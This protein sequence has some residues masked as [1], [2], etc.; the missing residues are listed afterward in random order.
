ME[1]QQQQQEQQ[2]QQ[3]PAVSAPSDDVRMMPPP[4]KKAKSDQ[5]GRSDSLP[6]T[7]FSTD[8][9]PFTAPAA[10][11]V[12]EVSAHLPAS[13]FDADPTA[14][15]ESESRAATTTA[16]A[17]A[18]TAAVAASGGGTGTA[19]GAGAA[20]LED[21]EA[22]AGRDG[23]GGGVPAGA[24]AE[25]IPEGFFD[26]HVQDAKVR[27]VEVKDDAEAEWE[28]FEK[29]KGWTGAGR[30]CTLFHV[31]LL[32]PPPQP[33]SDVLIGTPPPTQ[34]CGERVLTWIKKKKKLKMGCTLKHSTPY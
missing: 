30:V 3:P 14:S 25:T 17:V 15:N 31:A 33:P 9:A 16:A 34:H 12:A 6:S 23:G 4:V 18:A 29:G 1:K 24:A 26:D 5:S 32:P 2:Q 20:V 21:E 7:F 8:P 27:K 22:A 10:P 28:L 19:A 11:A 13:F